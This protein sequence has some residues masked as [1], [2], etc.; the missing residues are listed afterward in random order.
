MIK[1]QVYISQH[2]L[3]FPQRPFVHGIGVNVTASLPLWPENPISVQKQ[4]HRQ[5]VKRFQLTARNVQATHT[6]TTDTE[7][8]TV[9]VKVIVKVKIVAGFF[10][11]L[12]LDRG[13]DDIADLL[14]KSLLLELVS[15]ELN[16]G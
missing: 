6:S 11:S 10:S 13:I 4:V 5:K 2:T 1:P 15:S 12:R 7:K 14:G 3:L 9:R 16:P 8:S